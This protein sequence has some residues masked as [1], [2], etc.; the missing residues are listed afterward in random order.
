[1]DD[2]SFMLIPFCRLAGQDGLWSHYPALR[3]GFVLHVTGIH[4]QKRQFQNRCFY[5]RGL[6]ANSIKGL[7]EIIHRT[8]NIILIRQETGRPLLYF[9]D[10][11]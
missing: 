2:F 4:C 9:V 8:V 5:I 11:C 7:K 1:M 3:A 10:F 6:F